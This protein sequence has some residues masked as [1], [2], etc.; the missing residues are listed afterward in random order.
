MKK[1][2]PNFIIIICGIFFMSF[3]VSCGTS[4]QL[5]SSFGKRK[6]MPGHFY[7]R[8]TP[9][10]CEPICGKMSIATI[11]VS[12]HREVEVSYA[13][14]SSL[15]VSNAKIVLVN[16]KRPIASKK[17]QK[18]LGSINITSQSVAKINSLSTSRASNNITNVE[19]GDGYA[20]HH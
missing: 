9:V 12:N 18:L 1:N 20:A 14:T 10:K 7:D 4:N 3:L 13:S 11:P 19:Q 16:N 8:V 6:Y 17:L 5:A 2:N 15:T